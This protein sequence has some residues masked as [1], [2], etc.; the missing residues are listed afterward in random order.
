MKRNRAIDNAIQRAATL[1]ESFTGEAPESV[2]VAPK[3]KWP[4]VMVSIGTCDGIMY[5]TRQ[6]G[7]LVRYIHEFAGKAR[8][9]FAVSPDGKQ[10]FLLGGAYNF[11][12]RGIVDAR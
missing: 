7:K 4:E 5:T 2:Q 8:P 6:D 1:Y 11:T 9:T 10:L 12:E 3:P